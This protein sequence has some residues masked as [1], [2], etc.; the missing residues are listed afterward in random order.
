MRAPIF[1]AIKAAR[2]R[3]FSQPEVDKIDALLT[4]LGVPAD[5]YRFANED[6]FWV[7]VRKITG[8]LDQVQVDIIKRLLAET[9]DWGNG[10]LAYA[11]ATAWHES[12]LKPIEEWGKG[13]GREY[14]KVNSTGKAPYGRGLVQLTWHANYERAD[15][16]LGL[17]G[18]LIA[19][20]D[21]A[22]EPE[23]AVQIMVRGMAKGWFTGKSLGTYMAKDGFGTV[24]EFTQ[25]RRII[26]GT[27]KAAMIADYA[28]KFQ[29]ALV[30]GG[31]S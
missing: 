29:D 22:L 2:G 10:W 28:V 23:I 18:S 20:Y 17:G 6:A 25:A 21:R 5:D 12:R 3:G 9:N 26:N 4:A 16:E 1:D 8:Q 27:D 30:A 7:G 11:L 13:K 24:G 15:S 19:N 31:R 14:G